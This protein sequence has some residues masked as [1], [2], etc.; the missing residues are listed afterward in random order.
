MSP[1]QPRYS[2]EETAGAAMRSTNERCVPGWR[3]KITAESLPSISRPAHMP[4]TRTPSAVKRLRAQRPDGEIWFV[5]V[6][7]HALHRIGLR[8]TALMIWPAS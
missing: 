3:R 2:V 4:S 6:G 5:R 7:H 8:S 1:R